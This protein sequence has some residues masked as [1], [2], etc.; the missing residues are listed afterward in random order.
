MC[1][2][3]TTIELVE[4]CEEGARNAKRSAPIIRADA[5]RFIAI[6]PYGNIVANQYVE[7][8]SRFL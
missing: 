5:V 6:T 7:Y 3:P 2:I 1:Y 4:Q 8:G